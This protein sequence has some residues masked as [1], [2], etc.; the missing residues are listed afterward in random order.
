MTKQDK[1]SNP[2][3]KQKRLSQM[4]HN[5]WESLCD[6][7]GR[8]CLHKLEDVDNGDIYYTRGACELLDIDACRCLDYDNRQK[9]VPNCVQLSVKEAQYFD[10]LPSTCAYR[11]LAE[12]EDLPLW[13]PLIT[14]NSESVVKAGV[15]VKDIAKPLSDITDLS[16]EIILLRDALKVDVDEA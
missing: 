5:E 10:W 14:G 6:G 16:D 7:C 9:Q 11:L 4:D 15:S 2:F 12:G 1:T 13:H 8:C 3:W